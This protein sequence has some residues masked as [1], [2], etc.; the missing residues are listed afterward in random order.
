[1]VHLKMIYK[2]VKVVIAFVLAIYLV[3]FS[4]LVM[5]K[6]AQWRVDVNMEREGVEQIA[7]HDL[8]LY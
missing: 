8:G 2:A 3:F 6:F 1:M 5:A 7:E 4:V